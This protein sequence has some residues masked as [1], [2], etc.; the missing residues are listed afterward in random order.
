MKL[1]KKNSILMYSPTTR[2]FAGF[3]ETAESS[4]SDFL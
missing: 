2:D 1:Q 3:R 4:L